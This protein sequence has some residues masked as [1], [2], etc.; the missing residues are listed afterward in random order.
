MVKLLDLLFGQVFVLLLQ[1]IQV[2]PLNRVQEVHEIEQFT[3]VIVDGSLE[4]KS[5]SPSGG[6]EKKQTPVMMMR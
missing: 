6:T 5:I 4:M 2:V 1:S 3:D